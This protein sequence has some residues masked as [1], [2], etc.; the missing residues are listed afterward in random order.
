MF[1]A[2][3]IWTAQCCLYRI[4]LFSK[5][6]SVFIMQPNSLATVKSMSKMQASQ[7]DF[8]VKSGLFVTMSNGSHCIVGNGIA[9]S[10]LCLHT[11]RFD[12]CRFL[13]RKYVI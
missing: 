11:A 3:F 4:L 6:T 8:S 5:N 13:Y 9:H 2:D 12:S 7:L 1:L 10:L